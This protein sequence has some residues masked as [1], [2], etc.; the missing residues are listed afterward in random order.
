MRKAQTLVALGLILVALLAAPA[1]AAVQGTEGGTTTTTVNRQSVY[2]NRTVST[3]T[4]YL[5]PIIR[6]WGARVVSNTSSNSY[7]YVTQWASDWRTSY[8]LETGCGELHSTSYTTYDGSQTYWTFLRTST[9]LAAD[10]LVDQTY[11][12]VGTTFDRSV[13]NSRTVSG[14]SDLIIV[15]DTEALADSYNAR[16]DLN[17]TL[18]VTDYFWNDL[19]RTDIRQKIFNRYQ[20]YNVHTVYYYTT[21]TNYY[22]VT[23]IVLNMDGSG[24]LGASNGQW[25]SHQ[26][27]Q[28]NRLA[29]FDFF[30]SGEPVLMEWVGP[31]DGLLCTVNP[32]GSVDGSNLFGSANGYDNGYEELAATRDENGDGKISGAELVGLFVWQD[33]NGNA[34]AGPTELKSVQDL[35]ITEISVR[36]NNFKSTFV[37]KG[38]TFTSWDWH[39]TVKKVLRLQPPANF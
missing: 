33:A 2:T 18:D 36:P 29:L 20:D 9:E 17:V 28:G 24:K 8:Y 22:A 21:Y 30:G 14:S 15:G 32:D 12:Q 1:L 31:Q 23:P 7:N 26:K 16:G 35:G 38:Q 37:M 3:S 6:D 10:N 4:E 39:P 13:V 34:I 11:T 25:L 5:A 27:F 19:H